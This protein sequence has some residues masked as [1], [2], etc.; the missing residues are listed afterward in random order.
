MSS[1]WSRARKRLSA[2]GKFKSAGDLFL[3]FRIFLFAAAVPLLM[4][5]PLPRLARLLSISGS[6]P[7]QNSLRVEKIIDFVEMAREVGQPFVRR[8][9]QTRGLTLYYFL[10]R[11]GLDVTLEFGIGELESGFSGHCWLVKEG[12]PFLEARDPRPIYKTMYAV[13]CQAQTAENPNQI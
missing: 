10:I 3:F 9:C 4:R 1:Y 2:L 11:A 6:T 5:I 8:S 13:S 12:E 7:K